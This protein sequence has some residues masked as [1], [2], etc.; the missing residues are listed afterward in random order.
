MFF[1][2][3]RNVWRVVNKVTFYSKFVVVFDGVKHNGI[4]CFEIGISMLDGGCV[5]S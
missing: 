1:L 3:G 2:L 4:P 5:S